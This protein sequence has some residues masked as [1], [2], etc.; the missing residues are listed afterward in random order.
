MRVEQLLELARGATP[1]ELAR[2]LG[3][4]LAEC[5]DLLC[6]VVVVPPSAVLHRQGLADI[7][8]AVWYLTHDD[9]GIA[10]RVSAARLSADIAR[11]RTG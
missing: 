5:R 11:Q 8:I 6:D 7:A 9:D 2:R 3:V 4:D 10:A 1:G